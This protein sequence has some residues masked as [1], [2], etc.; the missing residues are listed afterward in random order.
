[1]MDPESNQ[2]RRPNN[3]VNNPYSGPEPN[4][5]PTYHPINVLKRCLYMG[6][7]LYGLH[8]F[9]A[10]HS[11]MHSPN[12]DHEAFKFG[13]ATTVAI[14]FIKAYVELYSGKLQKQEVNYQNFKQSTHAV[15]MLILLASLSF[16]IAL[17]GEYGSNSMF[18]MF[19]VGMFL[20]NFCLLAPTTIQN[21]V[22]VGVLTFFL[23]QYK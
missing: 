2:R 10:Y 19:L 14:L 17:W 13:I 5:L 6:I 21:I 16:H 3:N 23:Q 1:M 8:H 15:I 22:G 7:S 12:V 4:I 9:K 18:I 20:V 11:I